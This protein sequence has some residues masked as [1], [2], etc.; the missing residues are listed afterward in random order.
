MQDLPAGRV[1]SSSEQ[2][3]R[4]RSGG[5]SDRRCSKLS[6]FDRHPNGD[7]IKFRNAAAPKGHDRTWEQE[8]RHSNEPVEAQV[9]DKEI[10][11]RL[12]WDGF[13]QPMIRRRRRG[14]HET[15]EGSASLTRSTTT[16]TMA[17]LELVPL[18]WLRTWPVT[19]ASVRLDATSDS[20]KFAGMP[21]RRTE[22]ILRQGWLIKAAN[23]TSVEGNFATLVERGHHDCRRPHRQ[24][25][26]PRADPMRRVGPTKVLALPQ[27]TRS[28]EPAANVGRLLWPQRSKVQIQRWRSRWYPPMTPAASRLSMVKDQRSKSMGCLAKVIG[29]V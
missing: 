7:G 6:D 4:A 5:R 8:D 19:N 15:K 20:V 25:Q 27:R 3:L 22:K 18:G 10:K 29:L 14:R 23:I 1:D 9:I 2:W 13:I 11:H 17:R 26:S 24:G 21:L 12:V 16:P 28:L